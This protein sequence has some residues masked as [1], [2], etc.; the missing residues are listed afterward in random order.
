MINRMISAMKNDL[1]VYKLLKEGSS[2]SSESIIAI[3][4]IAV[5]SGL[6]SGIAN[7][8]GEFS[9]LNAGIWLSFLGTV[10]TYLLF[11][12]WAWFVGTKLVKGT[13][14][15]SDVRIALAYAFSPSIFVGLPYI[16]FLAGLWTWVTVSSA[17]R[18]TLGIGKGST[19]LIV[20]S[21]GFLTGIIFLSLLVMLFQV[22]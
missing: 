19:F 1:T 20:I 10:F 12:L 4:V 5:L 11:S 14:T 3:L 17:I 21:A 9:F 7:P 18:E 6:I 15:F 22:G 8:E 16:G 13:G 2:F